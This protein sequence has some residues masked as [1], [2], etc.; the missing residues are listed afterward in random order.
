M[1]FGDIKINLTDQTFNV[2]AGEI[3]YQINSFLQDNGTSHRF[4]TNV[5]YD[6][7]IGIEWSNN[8]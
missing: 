5:R 6:N 7:A 3:K 8:N 4:N 1:H 2:I